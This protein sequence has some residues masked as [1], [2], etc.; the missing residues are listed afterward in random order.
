MCEVWKVKTQ[1]FSKANHLNTKKQILYKSI[2]WNI[3]VSKVFFANLKLLPKPF[4]GTSSDKKTCDISHKT[5]NF[6]AVLLETH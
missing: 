4:Y 2:F 5:E 6:I 3:S 1:N